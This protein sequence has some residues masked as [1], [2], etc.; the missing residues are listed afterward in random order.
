MRS[1]KSLFDHRDVLPFA[2]P[3]NAPLTL[4]EVVLLFEVVERSG[5]GCRSDA[6]ASC[7]AACCGGGGGGGCDGGS[8]RRDV[9]RDFDLDRVG[10]RDGAHDGIRDASSHPASI[11]RRRARSALSTQVIS[12]VLSSC[13]RSRPWSTEVER[14]ILQDALRR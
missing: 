5:G 9:D 4:F 8:G 2:S 6:N 1:R 10:A 11:D 12:S 7:D 14:K 13:K 3:T